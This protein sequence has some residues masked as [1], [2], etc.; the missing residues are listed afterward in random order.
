MSDD[1]MS[2]KEDSVARERE[3][4]NLG[5]RFIKAAERKLKQLTLRD[6]PNFSLNKAERKILMDINNSGL[7]EGAAAG[8]LTFVA[9]RSL[10]SG[11]LQRLRQ[12]QAAGGNPAMPPNGRHAPKSP[13]QQYHK[14]PAGPSAEPPKTAEQLLTS[15][16][17]AEGARSGRTGGPGG[18]LL[19]LLSFLVDGTLSLFV[20]ASVSLRR[21]NQLMEKIAE[22]P[23]VEGHSGISDELCPEFLRELRLMHE[24]ESAGGDGAALR[25][26]RREA[27]R[28]PQT[29]PLQSLLAFCHNCQRRAVY[30]RQLRLEAGLALDAPVPIPPPGVPRAIALPADFGDL[31][32][33]SGG[34]GDNGDGAAW[35]DAEGEAGMDSFYGPD[36]R[37]IGGGNSS[38]NGNGDGDDWADSFPTDLEDPH[39]EADRRRG[40]K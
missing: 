13:F 12:A 1:N 18:A 5:L 31:G 40:K 24:E 38:N 19:S 9:L 23:L 6:N 4:L 33:G 10:R 28:N 35:G 11:L 34:G 8:I 7:L 27:L 36:S 30:E 25:A 16:G 37:Q 22:I 2:R 32:G 3:E 14:P 20:A 15:G 21:P 17:I 29:P 39:N 26:L